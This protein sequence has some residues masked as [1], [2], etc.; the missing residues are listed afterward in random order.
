MF[1][2][3]RW[4]NAWSGFSTLPAAKLVADL[5]LLRHPELEHVD[6]KSA[7]L[8]RISAMVI[9]RRHVVA[10]VGRGGAG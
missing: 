6:V 7:R 5:D 9:E 3:G 1:A 10:R 2:A 8:K 4:S